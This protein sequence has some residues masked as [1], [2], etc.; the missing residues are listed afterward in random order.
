MRRGLSALI[1]AALVVAGSWA[2]LAQAAE[3]DLTTITEGQQYLKVPTPQTPADPRKIGVEEFFWYGC[4]HCFHLEPK[5]EAWRKKLPADVVFTAVPN[6]LGRYVG[7]IHMQAFYIAQSLGV[8]D[9]IR[10]PLF[11]A[12]ND[13]H[14]PLYTLPALRDFFQQTAGVAPAQFDGLANSFAIDTQ[15]RHADQLAKDYRVTGTP[16]IVVGGKYATEIGRPGIGGAGLNESEAN[17]RLLQVVD[18]LIGKVRA[19]RAGK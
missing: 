7:R 9:K 17:T 15:M 18:L 8:E 3:G 16:F 10:K 5:L 2:G 1:G 19:E 4:I 14:L 12:L 11:T 6:D 13:E